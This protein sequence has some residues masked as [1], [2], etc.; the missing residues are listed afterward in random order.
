MFIEGIL[1]FLLPKST[2]GEYHIAYHIDAQKPKLPSDI[3]Y[4]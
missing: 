2:K 3:E 4:V 1:I